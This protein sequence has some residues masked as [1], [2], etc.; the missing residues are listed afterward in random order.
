MKGCESTG[1][2]GDMAV[3]CS[4]VDWPR[5]DASRMARLLQLEDNGSEGQVVVSPPI[6]CVETDNDEEYYKDKIGRTIYGSVT[7]NVDNGS[8]S[9][10]NYFEVEILESQDAAIAIGLSVYRSQDDLNN[11]EETFPGANERSYG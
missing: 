5:L 8:A 11:P 10:G 3:A 1:S 4:E 9:T 6:V 2:Y 7:Y